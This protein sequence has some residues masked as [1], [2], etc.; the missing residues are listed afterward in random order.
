M[1]ILHI[2][3]FYLPHPGGIEQVAYDYITM[4]K[5][6]NVQQKVICFNNST[7]NKVDIFEGVEVHRIGVQ[8][9]I[10]SQSIAMNYLHSL[11]C[12]MDDFRPQVI[13][14]H[15]P[16]PLITIFLLYVLRKKMYRNIRLVLLWHSDIVRIRQKIIMPLYM[17]F[18]NMILKKASVIITT[19]YYYLLDSRNLNRY[20]NKVHIV[21]NC[22]NPTIYS[23]KNKDMIKIQEIKRKFG[24]FAFFIGVHRKYKGLRYLVK[25]AKLLPEI[26]FVIAGLGPETKKIIREAEGCKNIHFIGKISDKDKIQYLHSAKIFVFP[27]ITKNEAFGVALAEAL[28]VGLPAISYKIKGSGVNWVNQN[29]KT[30]YVI[31]NKNYIEFSK[32]IKSLFED[33]D[34]H[35]HFSVEG[36]EWV[37]NNFTYEVN[38]PKIKKIMEMASAKK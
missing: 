13:L 34:V 4:L 37:K 24:E 9:K 19:S 30:G 11:K 2:S 14:I 6:K 22:V 7:K 5:N 28:S 29:G 38:I 1:N 18:Q 12:L 36:K 23:G 17:F 33:N 35:T 32:R 25:S 3:T 16:N 10:F 31:E 27:S 20:R 15:L 26:Q 21:P 8:F